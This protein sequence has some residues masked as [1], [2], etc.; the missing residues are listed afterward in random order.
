M[1]KHQLAFFLTFPASLSLPHFALAFASMDSVLTHFYSTPTVFLHCEAPL[2][3]NPVGQ[4]QEF[5]VDPARSERAARPSFS[6]TAGAEQA[7]ACLG[8]GFQVALLCLQ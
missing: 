8:C 4:F 1:I 5:P 6:P 7:V 2:E 3:G